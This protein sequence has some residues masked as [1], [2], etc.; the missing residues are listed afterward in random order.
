M[1]MNRLLKL[2]ALAALTLSGAA[3]A[4]CGFYVSSAGAD[5]FADASMVVLDHGTPGAG[6]DPGPDARADRRDRP[7][8]HP[9]RG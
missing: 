2:A 5:L 4:F 9:R 6:D 3:H 7:P 1:I 8:A